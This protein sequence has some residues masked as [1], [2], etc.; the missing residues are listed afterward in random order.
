MQFGVPYVKNNNKKYHVHKGTAR[1]ITN[2]EIKSC[3]KWLKD[4][5]ILPIKNLITKQVY[6]KE[7]RWNFHVYPSIKLGLTR[8]RISSN[9]HEFHNG[10]DDHVT[11]MCWHGWK[12][13]FDYFLRF[14]LCLQPNA[15]IRT[16]MS[17]L[18]S[19]IIYL[20]SKDCTFLFLITF[21]HQHYPFLTPETI[22]CLKK[23]I[24]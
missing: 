4:W 13:G 18:I 8:G 15:L 12:A 17:P 24:L 23:S 7:I 20:E 10:L 3:E 11:G 9:F 16:S 1:M 14:L 19:H 6:E 21:S 22:L 5:N 2:L